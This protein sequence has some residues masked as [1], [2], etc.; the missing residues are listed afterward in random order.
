MHQDAVQR[1]TVQL[2]SRAAAASARRSVL[3]SA[4]A[5]VR[6]GLIIVSFGAGSVG[7]DWHGW[8]G[9]GLWCKAKQQTKHRAAKKTEGGHESSR[10]MSES[11]P[12]AVPADDLHSFTII[13]R[14]QS[15][16]SCAGIGSSSRM[17]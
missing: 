3:G 4:T 6:E 1:C 8:R 11:H 12:F 2:T 10:G 7:G 15:S 14:T 17:R 13:P 5:R 9:V 16:G